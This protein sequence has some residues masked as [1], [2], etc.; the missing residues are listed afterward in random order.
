MP[1][2]MTLPEYAKG[3]E[4][5][6]EKAL[7]TVF[8][9]SSDIM[10]VLPFESMNGQAA[11]E[12]QRQASLPTTMAFRRINEPGTSGQ[13]TIE[14]FQESSFILD[15]DL[16]VD[17]AIVR[18]YGEGRRATQEGLG[19]AKFGRLWATTFIAGDN[20]SN[21]KEFN[22]IK[23]RIAMAGAS[24][25]ANT[26]TIHNSAASGG[27]ALSLGNLDSLLNMVNGPTH[28]IMS[29]LFKPRLIAAARTPAVSGN[30]FQT[31]DEIGKPKITYAG[32][33]ILFGYEREL[34]GE[35]LDFN[36][37]ASGGGGLVTASI[38]AVRFGEMGLRGLQLQ[39][40]A[41]RDV[42][43]LEDQITLRTHI[44][45]DVGLVDEHPFCLAR[46][47]SITNAAIVA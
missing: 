5:G 14:E 28:L 2:L 46:L 4:P 32:L 29:R 26:R 45:G 34:E 38:Y 10:Q 7:I 8:A 39:P 35:L 21:D 25:L 40:I 15:H 9:N 24:T 23:K 42:G 27:A 11:Y 1:D 22:G 37:A 43:I 44:S 36:E 16:D 17:S 3:L 6:T 33:P 41:A 18:R 30:I 31:W 47:D 20:T 19:M 12:Y 13:G